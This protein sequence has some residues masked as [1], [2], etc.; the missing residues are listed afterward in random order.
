MCFT[1]SRARIFQSNLMTQ[2]ARI[3]FAVIFM[4]A[5]TA[6]VES[7]CGS[8]PGTPNEERAEAISDTEIK[9]SWRV[10]TSGSIWYDIYISD[11]FQEHGNL[12]GVPADAGSSQRL[13]WRAWKVFKRLRRDT[14]YC[15]AIRSRT[16][17]GTEGCISKH[18]SNWQCATTMRF[19]PSPPPPAPPRPSQPTPPNP[20]R[21]CFLPTPCPGI[22][23]AI[24]TTHTCGP[25]CP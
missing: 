8:R 24:C 13:G 1:F 20:N 7:G 12:T 3:Y 19:A 22:P 11:P 16:G 21:C 6:P 23:G 5:A 4:I 9:Y 18:A 14:R 17:S 25:Q 10:T 15:F 2:M